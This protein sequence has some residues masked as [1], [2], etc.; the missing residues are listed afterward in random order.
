MSA[1]FR[2]KSRLFRTWQ[3][4]EDNIGNTIKG[5]AETTNVK[6]KRKQFN[7]RTYEKEE[8]YDHKY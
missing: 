8:K 3:N 1:N 6:T 5:V 2:P 7:T 4:Y